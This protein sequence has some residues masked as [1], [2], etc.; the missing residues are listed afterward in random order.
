MSK[1]HTKSKKNLSENASRRRKQIVKENVSNTHIIEKKPAESEEIKTVTHIIDLPEEVLEIVIFF[2]DASSTF[3]FASTCSY[4]QHLVSQPRIWKRILKR[5]RMEAREVQNILGFLKT[6]DEPQ[7]LLGQLQ[8]T[9]CERLASSLDAQSCIR[10]SCS[11]TSTDHRLDREHF[12]LFHEMN[13]FS[14][15]GD[16]KLLSVRTELY[17]E[18]SLL[19]TLKDILSQQDTKMEMLHME[20]LLCRSEGAGLEWSS[21]LRN[22]SAWSTSQLWLEG[23]AG[24]ITWAG[25]AGAAGRGRIR[26]VGVGREVLA[27]GG[28]EEV[29]AVWRATEDVWQVARETVVRREREEEGWRRLLALRALVAYSCL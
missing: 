8:H 14:P 28:L 11:R 24:A 15:G 7:L 21:I 9:L 6:V 20:V 10:V 4:F 17:I 1:V 3:T 2:L 16:H 18:G 23:G 25:M 12:L 27:R 26:A 29:R 22:C 5:T 13:A 19:T